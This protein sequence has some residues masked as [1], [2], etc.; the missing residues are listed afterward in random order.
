MRIKRGIISHRKHRKL[1]RQVK[2]FRMTK[3]RLIK[4]AK[5][6]SLHAGQY[7][8]AGRKLKKRDFRKLWIIRISHAVKKF[9]LNYSCFIKKLKEAKISLDRK[10]LANLII[11]DPQAFKAIIDKINKI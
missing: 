3:R 1:L 11:D 10:I 8:F 9:D 7:A 6:A 2:G 5:E 4:V